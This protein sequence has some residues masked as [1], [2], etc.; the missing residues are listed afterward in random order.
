[1]AEQTTNR[2]TS[3]RSR[4]EGGGAST[5]SRSH[6]NGTHPGSGSRSKR[7][8]QRSR[9]EKPGSRAGKGRGEKGEQEQQQQDGRGVLACGVDSV[10]SAG[11][12]AANAVKENPVPAALIGAGL[13]WLL[14]Q[15]AAKRYPQVGNVGSSVAKGTKNAIGTVG[16]GVSSA[17]GTVKNALSTTA[18]TV[19][20]SA[21]TVGEYTMSGLSTVGGAIGN[22]ASA[23]GRGAK[24]G[25][26]ATK[27]AVVSSW[28]NH[29]VMTSVAA[30]AAGLA[31]AMMV[32]STGP[33]RKAM[34]KRS[35]ATTGRAK[36][37]A[38]EFL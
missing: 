17:T 21:S 24:K 30:L 5:K 27:D 20:E 28:Q 22:G 6:D 16:E 13:A 7:G 18:E 1:M 19:K 8:E 2:R 9:G 34:G 31:V 12:T 3:S 25:A 32:P 10:K 11:S 38:K 33:E 29:P 26:T 15:G 23:V 4:G 37:A 14:A 35:A 36:T